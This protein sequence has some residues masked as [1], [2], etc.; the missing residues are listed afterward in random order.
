VSNYATIAR[1]LISE[2]FNESGTTNC[3][4]DLAYA[5]NHPEVRKTSLGYVPYI[6]PS[7]CF[8][9][10]LAVVFDFTHKFTA[11]FT[12]ATGLSTERPVSK[13]TLNRVGAELTRF[14]DYYFEYVL[15][16]GV[17]SDKSKANWQFGLGT[18]SEIRQLVDWSSGQPEDDLNLFINEILNFFLMGASVEKT[19]NEIGSCTIN[20]ANNYNF[21]NNLKTRLLFDPAFSILNQLFV[22]M[23]PVMVWTSGRLYPDWMFPLFDGYVVSPDIS[24]T[25]GF[26]EL[27]INCKDA[28]ELARV[29][30]EMINPSLIQ[31][32]EISKQTNINIFTQPLYGQDHLQIVKTLFQGG[33]LVYDPT[34]QRLKST[35][36][37]TTGAHKDTLN[38]AAL[39]KFD[40]YSNNDLDS[41]GS[42]TLALSQGA[43]LKKDWNLKI[44]LNKCSHKYRFRNLVIW[45]QSITPYRIFG[46]NPN[47]TVT[48]E[49]SSRLEILQNIA[50]LVYYNFYIDG[51]GNVNYHPMRLA[52]KFLLY[53][54]VDAINGVIIENQ[55]VFPGVQV[56]GDSEATN[57]SSRVNIEELVTFLRVEG[58]DPIVQSEWTQQALIGYAVDANLM[59]RFG[60]RRKSIKN[61]LL[62]VNPLLSDRNGRRVT[63]MDMCA[64]ALL[65]YSNGELYTS[66]RTIIFRP[67]LKLAAP[68]FFPEDDEIFNC[69]SIS[70]SIRVN[71]EATTTINAN[72]GRK[73][74]EI[75]SDLMSFILINEKITKMNVKMPPMLFD[76]TPAEIQEY[77]E[78]YYGINE[79]P[80]AKWVQELDD[81]KKAFNDYEN[82]KAQ[83]IADNL[84][85]L[86]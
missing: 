62:N 72:L 73:P 49:F 5:Q 66:S 70:H 36:V 67:E 55:Y 33:E 40:V 68:V 61:E 43:M 82:E 51:Y 84:R 53:E 23:V 77:Y 48:G 69:Q 30:T 54:I 7:Q 38:F 47:N 32:A 6:I 83:A 76:A 64:K 17:R 14:F 74:K 50:Q 58:Q 42:P 86:A 27:Q 71:G 81:Q 44:A 11:D 24:T 18:R 22:P 15:S 52:N 35:E 29:S 3:G 37:I 63:L 20:F 8:H 75:P 26:S 21:R 13:E 59:S 25:G 10:K 85:D 65:Q 41:V 28:L 16:Y 57:S 1:L 80:F 46:T 2:L 45:G 56:I 19:V 39:D 12:S 31:T 79:I 34:N 4:P 9:P 60:Y 78:S